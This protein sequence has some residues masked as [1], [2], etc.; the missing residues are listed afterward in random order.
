MAQYYLY[1]VKENESI[2]LIDDMVSTGGTLIALI[3]LLNNLG[4]KIV[5]VVCMVEKPDY[6]GAKIVKKETGINVK[7]IFQIF[8]KNE[9]PYVRLNPNIFKK[10]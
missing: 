1:G 9:K 6:G 10:I 2:L 8:I 3:K 7:T 5:D 4:I